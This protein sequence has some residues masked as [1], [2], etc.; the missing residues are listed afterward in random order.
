MGKYG[1]VWEIIVNVWE[2][3]GSNGKLWESM[4]KYGE[5]WEGMRKYGKLW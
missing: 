1:T 2:V 3:M 4:K 5:V